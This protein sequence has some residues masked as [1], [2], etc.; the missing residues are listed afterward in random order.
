MTVV[1]TTTRP[2]RPRSGPMV[3]DQVRYT[4]TGYWRSRVVLLMSMLIPLLWL[5]MIGAVAGNEVVDT[6]TGLRV[7]QFATP[8]ALTMG[9]LYG[10]LPAVA[11]TIVEARESGLLKRLRG[12]PLPGWAYLSG[13]AVG[14]AAFAALSVGVA[15]AVAVTAYD[16]QIVWRTLPATLVTLALAV[17]CF[18]TLGLA[19]SSLCR[20]STV[21]EAVSIG[22]VVTLSFISGLFTFGGT[23]P[24]PVTRVAGLLP[25]KPLAQT[26]Q[27]Q[28]N[29]YLS[30]AGWDLRTLTVLSAWTVAAAGVAAL[31]WGRLERTE[32]APRRRRQHVPPGPAPL[33]RPTPTVTTGRPTTTRLVA[34]QTE[35]ALR[36]LRRDP[37]TIFFAV[38]LPLGLFALVATTTDVGEVSPG[39][40]FTVHLAAGMAVWGIA[41]T[42]FMNIPETVVRARDRGVLKRLRGTPMQPAHYLAGRVLTG[43]VLALVIA[44]LV[45]TLG[46]TGFS[47]PVAATALALGAGLVVLGAIVLS[48][49]GFLL[50]AL[51]PDARTFAAVALVILLPVAFVSDIFLVGGPEWMARVGAVFPLK[52]FQNALTD[53]LAGVISTGTWW[54]L[55]VLTVWGL[56]AAALSTRFFRWHPSSS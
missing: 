5:F 52:H 42:T 44:A 41:V 33:P 12:T 18:V 21:A 29:P 48:A 31:A 37:G 26:L 39:V 10:S 27:D 38:L 47:M 30:G 50:A 32:G 40:P 9:V 51:T 8:L 22:G 43:I 15:L 3:A 17:V 49:C 2:H 20:S 54:H 28:F 11:I 53:V 34:A 55:G 46:A 7:M 24:D 56:V 35:A 16:V 25:V 1:T 19:I 13:R 14:A 36:T 6:S 23:L 45:M 4:L